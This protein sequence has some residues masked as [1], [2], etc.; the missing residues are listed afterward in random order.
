MQRELG[1]GVTIVGLNEVGRESANDT[2]TDGR[3]LPWLQDTDEDMVWTLWGI[4]YRDV[5]VLDEDNR[6]VDVLNLTTN[7][8]ADAEH[9]DTLTSWLAP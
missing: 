4:E 7:D 2:I 3:D 5:V 6:L 1:S 9:Y 8:L